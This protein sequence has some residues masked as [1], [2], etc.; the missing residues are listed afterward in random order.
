VSAPAAA[1]TAAPERTASSAARPRAAAR[2]PRAASAGA[3][4]ARTVAHPRAAIRSYRLV[5]RAAAIDVALRGGASAHTL[6][7]VVA[8]AAPNTRTGS[9][10][11]RRTA[12]DFCLCFMSALHSSRDGH[13][14]PARAGSKS[15]QSRISLRAVVPVA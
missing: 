1:A 7:G 13:C 2:R 8:P 6:E 4:C 9:V 11:D 5:A 15:N 10:A 12:F 3:A 14:S